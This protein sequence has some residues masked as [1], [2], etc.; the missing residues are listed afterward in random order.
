M[1]AIHALQ[2]CLIVLASGAMGLGE[3]MAI[4]V[5][6]VPEDFMQIR[7]AMPAGV[8]PSKCGA[9]RHPKLWPTGP[10]GGCRAVDAA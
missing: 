10:G 2:A 3:S 4:K 5:S 1:L 7:A 6:S 8:D 9:K